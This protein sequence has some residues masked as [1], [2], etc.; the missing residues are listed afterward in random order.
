MAGADVR[1]ILEL[2][3]QQS[4]MVT[5]DSLFN[6]SKKVSFLIYFSFSAT[7][8]SHRYSSSLTV[9]SLA[10]SFMISRFCSSTVFFSL[11]TFCLYASN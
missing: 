3:E 8:S 7:S 6:D 4:T 2:E 1:D 5:K 10:V 11:Y 9:Y